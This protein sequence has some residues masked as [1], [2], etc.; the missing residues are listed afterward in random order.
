MVEFANYRVWVVPKLTGGRISNETEDLRTATI[1]GL[2]L[3]VTRTRSGAPYGE[4]LWI[5][6]VEWW[7]IEY[8]GNR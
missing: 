2:W 1:E 5:I 8:S 6:G 4:F 7:R 3:G